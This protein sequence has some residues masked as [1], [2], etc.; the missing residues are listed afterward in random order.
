MDK[1]DKHHLD[2]T[3]IHGMERIGF[4]FIQACLIIQISTLQDALNTLISK[5]LCFAGKKSN[6]LLVCANFSVL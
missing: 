6:V 1:I 4:T 5:S 2:T 3:R